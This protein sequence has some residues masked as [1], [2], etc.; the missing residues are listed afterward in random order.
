MRTQPTSDD[1]EEV[2]KLN[3]EQ[4]QLDLLALN[5]S[6]PH[7]GP[8][9]D[10]M[11]G[12]DK[13]WASRV[14]IPTWGEMQFQLDDLNECVHFYFSVNRSSQKCP[15]CDGDGLSAQARPI[16]ESFYE[17]GCAGAGLPRSAAWHNKITED[18]LDALKSK[19]RI[20]NSVSLDA[21]NEDNS[22]F[23]LGPCNHDA[24]NRW[25]LIDARCKRLGIP[26]LCPECGGDGFIYTAPTAHVSLTLWI[27][28]PR[29]GAS[30][31]VEV[32]HIERSELPQVFA[33][34]KEAAQR[35]AERFSKIP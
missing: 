27:I 32:G 26:K 1:T 9:E 29:K 16:S 33:Y 5:P 11:T 2:S 35:N 7:W 24:I 25:I 10:Y 28:H 6:Y 34:L 15:E 12:D 20:P 19:H 21:V 31:G 17:H 18:E 8:Y 22:T 30:R 23:G 14:L 4:W 13:G 3:A